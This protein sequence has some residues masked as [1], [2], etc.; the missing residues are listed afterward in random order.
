MA[1]PL[2]YYT[3]DS[4]PCQVSWK[5]TLR[6]CCV[7]PT[8]CI[9]NMNHYS[10]AYWITREKCVNQSFRIT[11]GKQIERTH[12]RTDP[13]THLSC[14]PVGRYLGDKTARFGREGMLDVMLR[15]LNSSHF[16]LL[17]CVTLTLI[18]TSIARRSFSSWIRSIRCRHS[19]T[20]AS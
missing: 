14:I 13:L 8:L 11:S 17:S 3:P 18:R 9:M 10:S 2:L 4:P 12:P 16:L 6:H 19:M 7:S 5:V 20:M 15:R 1:K